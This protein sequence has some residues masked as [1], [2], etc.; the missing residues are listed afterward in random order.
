MVEFQDCIFIIGSVLRNINIAEVG[1]LCVLSS[2]SCLVRY[3]Y[4]NGSKHLQR[5]PQL[6]IVVRI[7]PQLLERELD[8]HTPVFIQF[9]RLK[10]IQLK[11]TLV[12]Q[13]TMQNRLQALDNRHQ[14]PHL[15]EGI[16]M[17]HHRH[18]DG[19]QKPCFLFYGDK[20]VRYG[21]AFQWS[22]LCFRSTLP[23]GDLPCGCLFSC[24]VCLLCLHHVSYDSF[25]LQRY[26][27]YLN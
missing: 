16:V 3:L 9:I 22:F 27:F 19:L 14:N 7:N 17:A 4:R 2:F 11:T 6:W 21:T 8:R 1:C 26:C 12:V 25:K 24:H 20:V 15:N 10:Q 13:N 23:G 18:C 5:I